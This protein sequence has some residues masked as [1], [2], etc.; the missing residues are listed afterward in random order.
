MADIT[1]AVLGAN[2]RRE[3]KLET[4]TARPIHPIR[5][6]NYN[7]V[8]TY[9]FYYISMT[10]IVYLCRQSELDDHKEPGNYAKAFQRQGVRLVCP[11][12]EFPVD[13][14]IDSLL[15]RCAEKPRLILSVEAKRPL[16]PSG[17]E[18]VSIPTVLF[19]CD[20][21]A[22]TEHRIRWSMLFDYAVVFHPGFGDIFRVAGHPRPITTSH[23]VDLTLF[24]SRREKR[25]FEVGWVG[26]TSGPIYKTRRS[27]VR[28]LGANFRMND[29]RRFYSPEEMAAVYQQS[30]VVVNVA[31]DGY[32]QDANMRVFEVMASGALLLTRVPSELTA[33]GFE[34]GVHFVGYKDPREIVCIIR[35][36]LNDADS[37]GRITKAAYEKVT[38]EHTYDCRVNQLLQ[39]VET[40]AGQLFAPARLWPSERIRLAYLDYYA[41]VYCLEPAYRLIRQIGPRNLAATLVGAYQISRA[42]ARKWYARVRTVVS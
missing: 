18:A 11:D 9:V 25:I 38:L 31:R 10:T 1:Q 13:G 39:T 30:Y 5:V 29:W 14:N 23:A 32:P 6:R 35:H 33:I 22:Y 27:V 28:D 12:D 34:E 41:A 20:T 26:Q 16:L 24:Q 19:N 4:T 36:Y 8:I 2:P 21:F 15:S 17:L 37:R 7:E 3:Q 40:D 42:I